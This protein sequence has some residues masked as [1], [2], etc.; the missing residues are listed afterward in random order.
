MNENIVTQKFL[1][2]KFC[3]QINANYGTYVH[4]L[5]TRHLILLYASDIRTFETKQGCT[6]VLHLICPPFHV[7]L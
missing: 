7:H 1:T 5:H 4:V 3:E 6:H 2:Q